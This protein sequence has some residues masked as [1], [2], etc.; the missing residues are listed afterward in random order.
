VDNQAFNFDTN[1]QDV[2]LATGLTSSSG[3][4]L[5]KSG[6]GTLVLSAANTYDGTTTVSAGTLRI[7]DG[8]SLG[9]GNIDIPDGTLEFT[10]STDT[11]LSNQL[12]VKGT[13]SSP[14]LLNN[15]AGLLTIQPGT[16]TN[17]QVD[18]GETFTVGGSGNIVIEKSIAAGAGA[19]L[20]TKTG[21]GTVTLTSPLNNWS[22]GTTIA[23][24]VLQVGDGTSNGTI[25][26]GTITMTNGRLA[27]DR[28][29]PYTI[30][31]TIATFQDGTT[32]GFENNGAG[33]LT[34]DATNLG[35]NI[36][37]NGITLELGRRDRQRP[38]RR[39]HRVRRRGGQCPEGR[40]RHVDVRRQQQLQGHHH[41]QRRPASDHRQPVRCDRR[42]DHRERRNARRHRHG[43]RR[44]HEPRARPRA[45]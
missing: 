43:R 42:R 16:S 28:P 10:R 5:A 21:S 35:F 29:D 32:P 4:T 25:G 9:T 20:L 45:S 14:A 30:A 22:G 8:G 7:A 1:G 36:G 40:R 2:T 34:I 17:I 23:A 12:F 18:N 15:G 19:S 13:G 26:S 39:P 37:A 41:R 11:S 44:D 3:G 33:L 38:S 31:E 6:T 24:G 27:F